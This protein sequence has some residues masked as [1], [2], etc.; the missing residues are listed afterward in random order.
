MPTRDP[1]RALRRR[2]AWAL[3]WRLQAMVSRLDRVSGQVAELQA[4]AAAALAAGRVLEDELAGLRTRV[5]AELTG[6][7]A[8]VEGELAP[9]LRALVA[10]EADNA[11]RLTAARAQAEYDFAWDEA[12]PLVSVTVATRDRAE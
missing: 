10:E 11:R 9:M 6:L 7:R 4:Q 1:L 3:D 2:L 8:R 5:E 12:E